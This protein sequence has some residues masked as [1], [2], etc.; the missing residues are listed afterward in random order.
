MSFQR[1]SVSTNTGGRTPPRE[2]SRWPQRDNDQRLTELRDGLPSSALDG[3]SRRRL[4]QRR[5][6]AWGYDQLYKAAGHLFDAEE[7]RGK[8]Y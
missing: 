3:V 5:R 4:P 7:A 8:G 1:R 6:D 2:G